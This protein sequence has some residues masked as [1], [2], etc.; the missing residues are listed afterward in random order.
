MDSEKPEKIFDIDGYLGKEPEETPGDIQIAPESTAANTT[1]AQDAAVGAEA[2]DVAGKTSVDPVQLRYKRN[3]IIVGLVL[4]TIAVV[5]GVFILIDQIDRHNFRERSRE[6]YEQTL[7]LL[8]ENEKAYNDAFTEYSYSIYG[9]SSKPTAADTYPDDEEIVTASH[10]CLRRFGID[11][12]EF[13]LL[14]HRGDEKDDYVEAND[15]YSRIS[16]NYT[17]ATASIERCR[18]DI[19]EPVVSAFGIQYG[20]IKFEPISGGYR[21]LMPSK[22][23]YTGEKSILAAT[24]T[25]ALYDKDGKVVAGTKGALT[26]TFDS[27]INTRYKLDFDPFQ[28]DGVN[29]ITMHQTIGADMK[30]LYTNNE[31]GV[32]SISGKFQIADE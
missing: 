20:E 27:T 9:L 19:L 28:V 32:Y 17:K 8:S 7:S 23:G 18:R 3:R 25:F 29:G 13:V 5:A 12:R 21:V 31:L 6:T 14:S 22:I 1:K 26:R 15:E 24:L 4:G 16:G 2:V 11:T 10:N 30:D